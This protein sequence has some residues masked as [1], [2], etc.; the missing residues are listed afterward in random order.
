VCPDKK[1]VNYIEN[2]IEN[3]KKVMEIYNIEVK[4]LSDT[5]KPQESNFQTIL[6]LLKDCILGIV[7]LDGL[8]S[9]VVLEYGILLC[10]AKPIIV[11]KDKNAKIDIEGLDD[12]LKDSLEKK[13]I[14][15]PKLDIDKHLSD[16]KDLHWTSY[17][18]KSPDDF[19]ENLQ[20]ELIK[21]KDKIILQ[22]IKP[23]ISEEI[24][25][26]SP[27]HY[28]NFQ[29]EFSE[30]AEY[31]IRFTE[32]DYG[33][34]DVIDKK[35]GN[36]VKQYKVK[37]HPAYYFELGNVYDGLSKYK[38]AIESFN[39]AIK[40][41]PGYADAWFNKGVALGKLGRYD[42]ALKAFNKAIEIKPD[43]AD[44]WY[45]KGVALHKLGR[46]D[47]AL[48]AFNKAI[49]IKPD[50]AD[51]WYNKGVALS[52]L[53]RYDEALKAHDKAIEIKP[54]DADAWYNK[55]NALSKLGRY[56]EALKAYDKAIEIKP[57]HADAW[58]NK[59][60]ALGE[61]GRY[62]EA[63]KAFNKAIE[64]KPDHADAWYNKACAYSLKRDKENALKSLSKA[65]ELYPEIKKMVKRDEDF[66]EFW[67][68]EDFKKILS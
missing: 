9:N 32:P 38:K 22:I 51:T 11:L 56:N 47:E 55:G 42:E 30:L 25:N 13:H 35:I 12:N 33:K 53:G 2:V 29:K 14:T 62:D 31:I 7:I 26:L 37:L 40:I 3:L 4:T 16:V 61:F 23:M 57:D 54:D 28:A 68:D 65:I 15:N 67:D 64:I 50:Y 60:V 46:Y 44:T 58:V 52:E 39:K 17:D 34:I 49:E 18:W 21:I 43:Y 19:E 24:K 8:R 48:K 5:V 27:E 59:G 6:Q 45:N 66:K 1:Y 41:E 36:L 10:L 20:H 63:L